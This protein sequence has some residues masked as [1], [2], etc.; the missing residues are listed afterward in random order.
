MRMPVTGERVKRRFLRSHTIKV[1]YDFVDY[2]QKEG[3]CHFEGFEN[4]YTDQYQVLQTFPRR[5]Y[6]DKEKSLEEAGLWPRG[7]TVQI[8]QL[9]PEDE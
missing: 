5:V 3:Q 1:L 2:L 4:K 7:G 6:E 8:Q 9:T